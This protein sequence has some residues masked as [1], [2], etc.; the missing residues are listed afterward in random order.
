M[1]ASFS[2]TT[3]RRVTGSDSSRSIV[4]RS[5]SPAI[6]RAPVATAAMM[7]SRGIMSEKS[8]MPRYPAAD[9]KSN[10]VPPKENRSLKSSG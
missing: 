9:V 2:A 5:S 6:A 8:S 4:P 7:S 3:R 1:A 10:S